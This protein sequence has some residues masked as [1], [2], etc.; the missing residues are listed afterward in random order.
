MRFAVL[1]EKVVGKELAIP[2][3]TQNGMIYMNRGAIIA[4]RH[5]NQIKKIGVYTVY[6][7][8]GINDVILQDQYDT[9]LRL[10]AIRELNVIFNN[11]KKYRRIEHGPVI[12]IVEEM[13]DNVSISENA[14]LYDN[15]GIIDPNLMLAN[16]CVNVAILSIIVGYNKKYNGDRL[17]K[18]GIGA[19]L[20]D[21]GKVFTNSE[22]HT[23]DGY[24]ICK[25]NIY[26]TATSNACLLHHHENEDGTGFPEG[27]S[28]LKIYEFAKI[29]GICDDYINLINSENAMLPHLAIE[30]ITS[31]VPKRFSEDIFKDFMTSVYCYPNGLTVRLNNGLEAMV[32]KQ[33]KRFPSRPI[34][35]FKNNNELE[36]VN[37]INNLTLFIQE[38][39]F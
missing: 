11:C 31:L 3:Y 28:G 15:I 13:I 21:L 36:T 5:I 24:K 9:N 35:A 38:V 12:R 14:Y 8:D 7:E 10:K 26:F 17:L 39:I 22:E 32:V 2:I 25:S 27:V 6:I 23:T 33:N 34:I 29:V 16:H 18:L 30:K 20:H 19:L 37:L 4:E 1:N